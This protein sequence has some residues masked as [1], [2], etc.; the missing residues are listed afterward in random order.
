[1][2]GKKYMGIIRSAFLIDE[3]G[4][5]AR[6]LVQDQ[7]EG[8]AGEPARGARRS[9]RRRCPTA[10]RRPPASAA[11][12]VRRRGH[13]ARA[14]RVGAR[15]VAA[16]RRRVVLPRPLPGPADAAG[17]A[18]GRVDRAARCDRRAH[19]PSA[20][21]ASCRCS[22]GSTAAGSAVRSCR[23]TRS[24]SRSSWAGCRPGPARA[25]GKASV[26][27]QV[28]CEAELLFVRRRRR[29]ADALGR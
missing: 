16:H 28:A 10:D 15:A 22:A 8:H 7:P 14:G 23:A 24:S 19:R 4:K 29:Q 2:Y 20:S 9:E 6:G 12:P 26:D 5:I 27:G 21:P 11:V 17:R 13:R 18:D 1:M 25:R 3:K